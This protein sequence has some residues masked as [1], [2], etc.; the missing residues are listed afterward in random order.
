M[1]YTIKLMLSSKLTVCIYPI[2]MISRHAL[3]FVSSLPS[4]MIRL[5][6]LYDIGNSCVRMDINCGVNLEN[7]A[8]G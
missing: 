6:N 1:E 7:A 2:S 8:Y 4:R 3:S 5:N